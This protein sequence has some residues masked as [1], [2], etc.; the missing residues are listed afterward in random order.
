[1]NEAATTETSSPWCVLLPLPAVLFVTVCIAHLIVIWKYAVDV[2]YWDEWEQL[3]SQALPQG[4]TW[5]WLFSQH[6]EHRIVPTNLLT[7]LLYRLDGWDIA[8]NQIVNWGIYCSLVGAVYWLARRF[9]PELPAWLVLCFLIFLFSPIDHENHSW[10]IQSQVHFVLLFSLLAIGFLFSVEQTN[11]QLALGTAAGIMAILSFAS[12]PVI[13]AGILGA[14]AVFKFLRIF[15]SG[16]EISKQKEFFQ[17]ILTVLVLGGAMAIWLLFFEK[18]AGHPPITLPTRLN[19]W[20]YFVNVL[21]LGFGIERISTPIGM[22]CFGLVAAAPLFVLF[23]SLRERKVP[24]SKSWAFLAVVLGVFASIAAISAGRAAFPII[25]AKSSRYSEIAMLLVPTTFIL[26]AVL[27]KDVP[28]WRNLALAF[29]WLFCFAGFLNNWRLSDYE[30]N[31]AKKLQAL[32][33]I[34]EYYQQ[35]SGGGCGMIYPAPIPDRLNLARELNVSFY[36]KLKESGAIP[37]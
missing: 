29:L 11:R 21:S 3:T 22:L 32:Q 16:P 33:C 4:L 14:F 5:Q 12:G 17:L 8:V 31:R 36:R 19:F 26:W 25:T 13:V 2:P 7:W 20:T 15:H 10:G 23:Q 6:N 28:R 30:A 34:A 27:L 35:G 9:A 24:E 1:M 37:D 18:P